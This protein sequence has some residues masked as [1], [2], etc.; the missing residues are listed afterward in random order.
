MN[1]QGATLSLVDRIKDALATTNQDS[2]GHAQLLADIS[3]LQLMVE[4][5][6]ETIYRIGHQVKGLVE[7]S[8]HCTLTPSEQTWQNACVRIVLEL[9]VFD[10]LIAK[11]G[12]AANVQELALTCGADAVVL[13]RVMRVVT[14]LG[15]CSQSGV[16]EY[17]ANS[18]TQIMTVPQGVSSFKTW[19][20]IFTPTA[21]NFP[22]Y[23]RS[24]EY[25][26]PTDSTT[27]AFA[28]TNGSEFWDYLKKTPLQSQTFNDFMATR[29]Q[30]RPSWYDIY[31]VHHELSSP[32]A[33]ST[34]ASP[35]ADSKILLVDVGGNRGHDLVNLKTKHPNLTGRMILQDL[36][37]VV[38][39]ASFSPEDNIEAMPHDFF[40][41]QP[42]KRN[43]LLS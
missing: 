23:M 21:T 9:G 13:V 40:Q 33:T 27:S 4:T 30:G 24:R 28:Y 35:E 5:P 32:L 7:R 8:S 1:N 26:N 42:I 31:P 10:H 37:D 36:P 11:G 6:L 20:D 18:K 25:V 22:D 43:L 38:T 34:D 41:P 29:R 3:H 16:D 17:S 15:L 12:D 19:F 2:G 14:A 39:H